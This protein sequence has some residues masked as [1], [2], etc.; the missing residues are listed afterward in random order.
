MYSYESQYRLVAPD[1]NQKLL[2]NSI[3]LH[4]R[5]YRRLT[6]SVE[7]GSG[8]CLPQLR[9]MVKTNVAQ[10]RT[11]MKKLMIKEALFGVLPKALY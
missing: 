6:P 9:F 1:F 8:S 4:W 2:G 3:W 7:F 10:H 5:Y 11:H